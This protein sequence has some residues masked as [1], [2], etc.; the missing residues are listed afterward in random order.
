M[1]ILPHQPSTTD[2]ILLREV[3][4]LVQEIKLYIMEDMLS[5]D[6]SINLPGSDTSNPR[7]K[8]K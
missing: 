1:K 6:I 5:E 8:Q 4:S 2:I 7:T 3:A